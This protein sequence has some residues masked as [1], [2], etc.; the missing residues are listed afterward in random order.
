[1]LFRTGNQY[2]VEENTLLAALAPPAAQFGHKKIILD[3]VCSSFA[4]V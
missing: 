2:E 1:M 3:K 4:E